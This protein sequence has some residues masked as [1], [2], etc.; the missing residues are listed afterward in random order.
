M[1]QRLKSIPLNLRPVAELALLPRLSCLR[2]GRFRCDGLLQPD[3]G[4]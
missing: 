1:A 4:R 2:N 3:Q